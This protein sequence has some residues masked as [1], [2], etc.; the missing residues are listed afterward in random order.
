LRPARILA[1]AP[2]YALEST[3]ESS[4]SAALD[5]EYFQAAQHLRQIPFDEIAHDRITD[6]SRRFRVHN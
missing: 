3:G 5:A 6:F 4:G 1:A 2:K